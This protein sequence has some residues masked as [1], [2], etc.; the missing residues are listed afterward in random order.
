MKVASPQLKGSVELRVDYNYD[1]QTLGIMGPLSDLSPLLSSV[2][3]QWG[4]A[5]ASVYPQCINQK[6]VLSSQALYTTVVFRLHL[7]WGVFIDIYLTPHCHS[8]LLA[9]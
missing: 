7:T 9:L 2:F 6:K 1:R 5:A 3:V 8:N 4:G